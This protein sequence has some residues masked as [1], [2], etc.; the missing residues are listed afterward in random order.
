MR[1]SRAIGVVAPFALAVTAVVHAQPQCPSRVPEFMRQGT[2]EIAAVLD[3][4]CNEDAFYEATEL[5]PGGSPYRFERRLIGSGQLA[6]LFDLIERRGEAGPEVEF[7]DCRFAEPLFLRKSGVTLRRM[8]FERCRFEGKVE[9]AAVAGGGSGGPSFERLEFSDCVFEQAVA[10]G[11]GSVGAPVLYFR[12]VFGSGLSVEGSA[13]ELRQGIRVVS[14]RLRDLSV[15]GTRKIAD[16]TLLDS[17][18]LGSVIVR[19]SEVSAALVVKGCTLEAERELV[20]EGSL[21]SKGMALVDNR[22]LSSVGGQEAAPLRIRLTDANLKGELTV[23]LPVS[24]ALPTLEVSRS[25]IPL[26]RIPPWK[27]AEALL[28]PADLRVPARGYNLE[29]AAE[30][31]QL[32]RTSYET[33]GRMR[34][35]RAVR[36]TQRLLLARI[37]GGVPLLIGR[38]V[39]LFPVLMSVAVCYCTVLSCLLF[40]R[41]KEWNLGRGEIG[42]AGRAY[43][44]LDLAYRSLTKGAPD[45]VT[46]RFALICLRVTRVLGIVILFLFSLKLHDWTN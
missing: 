38:A 44:A 41:F 1:R 34:D 11:G 12:D 39:A 43:A 4:Y 40:V 27:D 5:L 19:E 15:V 32:A 9:L 30:A 17:Q 29:D 31:L 24:G 6:R 25:T 26:L 36:E 20:V 23:T 14:S 7:V 13:M 16:I 33:L 22:Y 10:L 28:I 8:T 3:L 37:R 35:A 18:V 45:T 2:D 21:L 42:C 46:S